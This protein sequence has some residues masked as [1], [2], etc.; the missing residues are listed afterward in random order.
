MTTVVVWV[1][2]LIICGGLGGLLGIQFDTDT[3]GYVG[4]AVGAAIFA[5]TAIWLGGP[6]GKSDSK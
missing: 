6:Y 4:M 3:G 1:I 2:G 5:A